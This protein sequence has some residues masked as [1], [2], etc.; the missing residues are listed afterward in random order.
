VAKSHALPS[1]L[2]LVDS[3]YV[4]NEVTDKY[5]QDR[6]RRLYIRSAEE[7]GPAV[8]RF[9]NAKFLRQM[10]RRI[11]PHKLQDDLEKLVQRMAFDVYGT[12]EPELIKLRYRLPSADGRHQGGRRARS[13]VR[14]LRVNRLVLNE[15]V[16]DP[17]EGSRKAPTL[18]AEDDES[19]TSADDNHDNPKR[20]KKSRGIELTFDDSDEDEDESLNPPP[21]LSE[22]QPPRP[23]RSV[24]ASHR[25]DKEY[26]PDD[27]LFDRNG[28]VT[29]RIPWSEEEK[30]AVKK[31]VEVFGLGKWRDIKKHF[32]AVLHNRTSVQIKDAWR[33]MQYKGEV[34]PGEFTNVV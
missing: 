27:G 22:L 24:F 14:T 21:Q 1:P 10:F 5:I 25:L 30:D 11:D 15:N 18:A 2:F 23:K 13:Q 7:D 33:T 28:N 9:A 34:N 3:E 19:R 32:R 4:E 12:R 6:C 31:G 29:K 26:P 20:R 8:Y 16:R 17:L